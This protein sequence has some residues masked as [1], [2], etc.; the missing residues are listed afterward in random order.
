MDNAP[1]YGSGDSRFESWRARKL[2]FFA[3]RKEITYF[4]Y[5]MLVNILGKKMMSGVGFEPTPTF[6][7]QNAPFNLYIQARLV[8]LS[9]AP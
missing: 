6:V 9:L 8:A 3:L 5:A 4:Q 2:L 7:D 1:D